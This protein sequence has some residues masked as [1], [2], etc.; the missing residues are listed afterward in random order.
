MN[1][2][3]YLT[4]VRLYKIYKKS[5]KNNKTLLKTKHN[6]NVDWVN[7]IWKVY[8]IPIDE[9][10]NVRQYGNKYTIELAKKD[11]IEIDKTMMQL[12]LIE[13]VGLIEFEI[14][15]DFNIKIVISY[16]YFDLAK[17]MNRKILIYSLLGIGLLSSLLLFLF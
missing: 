1:N 2:I 6:L 17:R 10:N 4:K 7:R 13:M 16:K 12:G 3:S 14:I 9:E 8:T 5:L 11:L 15:N